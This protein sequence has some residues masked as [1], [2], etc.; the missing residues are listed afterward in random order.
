VEVILSRLAAVESQ[1]PQIMNA[2]PQLQLKLNT[3]LQKIEYRGAGVVVEKMPDEITLLLV[4]FEDIDNFEIVME[5]ANTFKLMV[6]LRKISRLPL[7]EF[8][9]QTIK[10]S[11]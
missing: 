5:S 6:R 8:P 3:I 10:L 11:V 2:L 9:N 1:Q 4:T 7:L